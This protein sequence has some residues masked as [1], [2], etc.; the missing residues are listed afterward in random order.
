M[1]TMTLISIPPTTDEDTAPQGVDF[2]LGEVIIQAES[3]ISES[4]AWAT[5]TDAKVVDYYTEEENNEMITNNNALDA[6]IALINSTD[7]SSEAEVLETEYN[8]MNQKAQ[9]N[10][11]SW[12]S[13]I[14]E[15][16]TALSNLQSFTAGIYSS[17]SQVINGLASITSLINHLL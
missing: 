4:G 16:N 11:Q 12:N 14:S 13:A 5:Q 15:G 3:D 2:N 10:M 9:S 8:N 17:L 6:Q 7:D 1:S